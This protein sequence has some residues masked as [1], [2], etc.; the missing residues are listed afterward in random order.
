LLFEAR[1]TGGTLRDGL[2]GSVK[3]FSLDILPKISP[4][5]RGSQQALQFYLEQKL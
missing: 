5:R 1:A 3:I 2:E 4:N